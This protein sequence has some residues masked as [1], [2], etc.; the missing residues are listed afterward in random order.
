MWN[1]TQIASFQ[2]GLAAAEKVAPAVAKLEE[3]AKHMPQF[4]DR[5]RTL[6]LRLE[7]AKTI[8]GIALATDAQQG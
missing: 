5:I 1:K 3:L 7:N 4:E 2:R 8:A 6:A